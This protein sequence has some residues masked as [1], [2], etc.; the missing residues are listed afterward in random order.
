VALRG[1]QHDCLESVKR[2]YQDGINLQLFVLPTASGKATIIAYLPQYLGMSKGEQML[3]L[4]HRNDL[5]GQT[6]RRIQRYNP[7]LLVDIEQGQD[8]ANKH[9]DVIVASVQSISRDNRLHRFN[10]DQFK[11]VFIDEAHVVPGSYQ[12]G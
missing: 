4:V 6:A 1:Y 8:R 10:P 3:V 2:D 7:N 9:A 11:I 5:V 12:L